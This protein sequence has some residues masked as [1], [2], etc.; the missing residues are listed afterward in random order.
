MTLIHATCV[1]LGGQGILLLGKSGAGKSDLALRLIDGGGILIGDDYVNISATRDG[2]LRAETVDNIAG[3]IEVRGVGL[4]HMAYEKDVVVDL[5]LDL[6]RDRQKIERLAEFQVSV[7]EGITLP[8]LPFYAFEA[9]AVA[10]VRAA[11]N[12]VNNPGS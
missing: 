9:S 3:M 6:V 7:L 11:L 2:R 10:K 12:R 8:L 4:V 5:I 1:S